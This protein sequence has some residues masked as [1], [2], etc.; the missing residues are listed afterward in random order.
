MAAILW[1]YLVRQV[2]A[3]LLQ[4]HLALA[5]L[6]HSL[7]AEDGGNY[8]CTKNFSRKLALLGTGNQ[9]VDHSGLALLL[10]ADSF[11]NFLSHLIKANLHFFNLWN[12]DYLSTLQI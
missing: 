8:T 10:H 5:S 11:T 7:A 12:Q 2:I 1:V 4:T 3:L 6:S 9:P